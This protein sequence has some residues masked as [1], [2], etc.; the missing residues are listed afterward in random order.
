MQKN[1]KWMHN[2]IDTHNYLIIK[3]S[4]ISSAYKFDN[5]K[6]WIKVDKS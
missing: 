6:L 3:A 5:N 1:S 2:S 4:K